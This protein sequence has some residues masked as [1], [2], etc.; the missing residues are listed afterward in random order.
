MHNTHVKRLVSY[1]CVHFLVLDL[2]KLMYISMINKCIN[3]T[4]KQI[5]P[6]L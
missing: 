4:G 3:V 2:I 5:N 6:K 1:V